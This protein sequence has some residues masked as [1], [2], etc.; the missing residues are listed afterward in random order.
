MNSSTELIDRY[1]GGEMPANERLAFEQQLQ[2]QPALRAEVE[3][4]REV[5]N[6]IRRHAIKAELYAGV[7]Q[8]ERIV[9]IRRRLAVAA[10][11][12][13]LL[14]TL[15]FT[16]DALLPEDS[17]VMAANE[18]KQET[19]ASA[20]GEAPFAT[21]P[22]IRP[23]NIHRTVVTAG[24]VPEHTTVTE[25]NVVSAHEASSYDQQ[26]KTD[27]GASADSR[28]LDGKVI[29]FGTNHPTNGTSG[30]SRVGTE[31]GGDSAR[32]KTY[33]ELN[34]EEKRFADSMFKALRQSAV[35][36]Q[37]LGPDSSG[38]VVIGV[39]E[40]SARLAG[41]NLFK[42]HCSGCHRLD[43]Q[44]LEGPGLE[45]VTRRVPDGDWLFNYILN[46]KKVRENG[47][48][49]ARSIYDS[50]H[51]KHMKTFEGV[52]SEAEVRY[53]IAFLNSKQ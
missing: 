36:K 22:A 12:V 47:D 5:M 15:F 3:L 43:A 34:P 20:H 16:T 45:G 41:A 1:L 39:I 13:L 6:G 40:G 24:S 38:S 52:L 32:V 14:A 28:R 21:P 25:K 37:H 42:L 29:V 23:D 18:L 33:S 9:R 48:S 7:K 50:R 35:G 31:T 46:S 44:T 51:K 19:G 10:G 2:D 26:K 30:W 49:Y 27:D 4:Q 11:V 17:S 53:I 8:K